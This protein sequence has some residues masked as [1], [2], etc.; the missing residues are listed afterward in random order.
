MDLPTNF[1]HPLQ[2][3][4][5]AHAVCRAAETETKKKL[6]SAI[7]SA[8]PPDVTT[9]KKDLADVRILGYLLSEGNDDAKAHVAKSIHSVVPSG[10]V[11]QII[12]LGSLFF[13]YF[14]KTCESIH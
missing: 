1:T 10:N 4:A 7:K 5:S 8:Q 13:T 3:I 6:E 2:S 11:D 12:E 14:I 9:R